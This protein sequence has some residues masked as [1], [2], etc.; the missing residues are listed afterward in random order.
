MVKKIDAATLQDLRA[1]KTALHGATLAAQAA[2]QVVRDLEGQVSGIVQSAL[3]ARGLEPQR[4]QIDL[5]TGA[6]NPVPAA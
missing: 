3:R 1:A 4:Y 6:I 5:A 2:V